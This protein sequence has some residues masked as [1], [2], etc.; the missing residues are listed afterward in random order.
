VNGD[1]APRALYLG[2]QIVDLTLSAAL[3]SRIDQP[4]RTHDHLDLR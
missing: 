2:Q 3:Y 1:P 4:G